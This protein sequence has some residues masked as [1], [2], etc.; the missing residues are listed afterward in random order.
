[1][2][3]N[4]R[5]AKPMKVYNLNLEQADFDALQDIAGN[6]GLPVSTLL[7]KIIS[8]FTKNKTVSI[9]VEQKMGK[10]K[11]PPTSNCAL[12]GF[13]INLYRNQSFSL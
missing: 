5:V 11:K 6:N 3:P 8:D 7:R 1:M 4:K 12:G 13:V 9:E 10:R 2:P